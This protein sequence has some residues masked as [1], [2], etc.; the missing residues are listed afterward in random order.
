M[1][2]F[3]HVSENSLQDRRKPKKDS[4][5][6]PPRTVEPEPP[7]AG[8]RRVSTVNSSMTKFMTSSEACGARS[9]TC[10]CFPWTI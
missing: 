6:A 9:S 8:N 2:R 3:D 4:R 7:S 10:A 1:I 5:E